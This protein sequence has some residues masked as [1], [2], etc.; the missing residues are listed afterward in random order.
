MGGGQV[1]ALVFC[2]KKHLSMAPSLLFDISNIDIDRVVHSVEAIEKLNPHRGHMR[3]LDRIVHDDFESG[4]LIAFKD[5]RA[6]EFW[7]AGHIP[8]R[9]LLPG[10]LMIEAAAQLAS[11]QMVRK[12]KDSQFMG[13]AG[14]D[15]VKFRGQVVPGD[16]L[17]IMIKEVAFRP[18][19]S[20]CDAQGL[21]NGALVFEAKITGM[22][23]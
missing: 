8:G 19:R 16:Q 7:V 2:E 5:V 22:P 10:V 13:F 23:I 4:E 15:D 9:P 18:R 11:F 20:V 17:M 3:M 1:A 21:V 12:M 6:E 14:V